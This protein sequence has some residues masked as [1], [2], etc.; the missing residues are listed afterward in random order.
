MSNYAGGVAPIDVRQL[1]G[2]QT[3][4]IDTLLAT[5]ESLVE[6]ADQAKFIILGQSGCGKSC[7]L[8]RYAKDDFDPLQSPTIGVN[9]EL[10]RETS[11]KIKCQIFDTM[12]VEVGTNFESTLLYFKGVHVFLLCVDLAGSVKENLESAQRWLHRIDGNGGENVPVILVGTKS[13]V[14]SADTVSAMSSLAQAHGLPFICVS[15]KTGSNV[16]YL[17]SFA[18]LQV[19]KYKRGAVHLRGSFALEH[20]KTVHKREKRKCC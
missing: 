20:R 19:M 5:I 17:F 18:L 8:N 1:I 15:A 3:E 10:T 6:T 9:F 7:L 14:F 13:D 11:K 12:G 2:D 16:K 4:G